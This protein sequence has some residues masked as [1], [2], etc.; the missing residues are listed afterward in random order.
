[1]ADIERGINPENFKFFAPTENVD[2]TPV[3]QN[4][5]YAVYI[6]DENETNPTRFLDLPS[7]LNT[8]VDG[9]FIVPIEDFPV[10]RT[11]LA[12]TATDEDGDESAFSQTLGFRIS[13]GVAPNPPVLLAS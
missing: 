12:L 11:V 1:M 6:Y 4:L 2:G 13:D 9:A 8:D 7:T 3:T 5:T 10:G